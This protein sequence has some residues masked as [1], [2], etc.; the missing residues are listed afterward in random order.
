M[1]SRT[2]LLAAFAVI[3]SALGLGVS[4]AE[5]ASTQLVLPQGTAFSFLGH[6]CGG[7]QEK[8]YAAGFDSS[9][10]YPT[11]DA[12]LST[13]CGGSG[14]GGGYHTTTYT[15]WVKVVWDYTT[16]VV[17]ASSEAAPSVNPS[18]VVY[19]QY[20]NELYNQSNSAFL[21]LAAG[22]VPAP[23]VVG[24]TPTS[25]PAAGGTSVT[26]TGTGFS[27]VTAVRF[28]GVAARSYTV[29][30]ST[31]ITAVAPASAGTVDVSVA[32]AGGTSAASSADAFTFIPAPA[33]TAISPKTGTASG[34]TTVTITGTNLDLATSVRFGG[35]YAAF[36]VDDASTITAT[37]PVAE[38]PG[39]VDVTVTSAGGT[40]TRTTA[41]RFRY[42][43]ALP[44]VSYLD[45]ASGS[46][47]G[48]TSVTIVGSGFTGATAVSFGGVP[49]Q[50]VVGNSG[51]ITAVSPPGSGIVDVTVTTTAGTSQVNGGDEFTYEA[52]PTVDAVSPG[53]GSS[54]GGDLVLVTGSGFADATEVDFGGVSVS[55]WAQDDGTIY[56]VSPAASAGTVDVT[57]VGPGGSSTTS[58]ADE[59]TFVDPPSIDSVTPNAG[60]VDGGDIVTISG[61]NLA[62]VT[63][64]DFGGVAADFV[65]NGDGT[66]TAV[67][68]AGGAGT[69]DV[70][71]I[72][73]GGSSASTP[74]DEFTYS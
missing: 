8:V 55:F 34:G 49:A 14:R 66:I 39:T 9:T 38:A 60:S 26:I 63:E 57:V 67:S 23:R 13:S 61:S 18:L 40:S 19:D 44:A 20:G 22:F 33:V 68:P 15:A 21:A 28:G 59:Y 24:I 31:S 5:A 54:A 6:S 56:A 3:V 17:S 4:R 1:M 48:G 29:A 46:T 71:V 69:A 62:D 65:V 35:T 12:Y 10:G 52:P 64:V 51:T 42:T 36:A 45:P 47:D 43:A 27:G 53:S 70:T 32:N 16:A 72:G 11:G 2:S 30:S 41:D 37:S 50:Y 73:P 7:I 74:N 58:T 25:G